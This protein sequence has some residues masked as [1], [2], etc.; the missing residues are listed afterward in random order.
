MANT[1]GSKKSLRI[2]IM[3]EAVQ[4]SDIVGVDIF[5]NLSRGYMDEVKVLDPSIAAFEEHAVDM[6]FFYI[7]T[8]LEPTMMVPGLN[9]TFQPNVTYDD[10]PRDLD[11]VLI[12]GP[13]PAHRPAQADK[14]IK[15]AWLKTRVWI[16][17]C[18][19][20][21]WLASAGVLEGRKCTTNKGFLGTVQQMYP[22]TEWL[23]QRW[24]VDDKPYDGPDGK[25]ELWTSGGAG[26]GIEMIAEYCL[27]NFS[28]DFVTAL[29]LEALEFNPAG[30]RGQFYSS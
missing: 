7:A 3:L 9:F 17:T 12:G 11:L 25:G 24:V 4:L 29:A 10:C 14:F 5:G 19:G 6:E 15:E 1:T 30:S 13:T 28:R 16:T 20:S 27:K 21:A 8:T 26:A 2:G 18:I 22:D 23:H